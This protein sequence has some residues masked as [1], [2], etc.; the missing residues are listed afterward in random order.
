MRQDRD[1]C[2]T[3]GLGTTRRVAVTVQLGGRGVKVRAGTLWP[4]DHLAD[5][6]LVL[7]GDHERL[8]DQVDLPRVRQ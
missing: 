1:P 7:A 3:P 4:D 2:Q 6:V 5:S 8:I